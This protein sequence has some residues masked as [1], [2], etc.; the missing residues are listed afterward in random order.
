MFIYY[1]NRLRAVQATFLFPLL[2]DTADENDFVTTAVHVAGD[3]QI[4]KNGGAFANT[5][6][7]FTHIGNG[8]YSLVLT[9][10]EMNAVQI[11]VTV[12]DQTAVKVWRD[13]MLAIENYRDIASVLRQHVATAGGASTITLDAGASAVNDAYK[14]AQISIVSGT[15]TGQVRV[16]RSYVG[17][18]KVATVGRPWATNPDAT[19][20]YNIMGVGEVEIDPYGVD[21]IWDDLEGTEPATAI[22]SN[23]TMRRILQGLKRWAFNRGTATNSARTIYKDDSITALETQTFS[24]D[25]TTSDRGKSA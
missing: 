21:D 5:I 17:A 19:S 2:V 12:V 15:G 1:E 4:S 9:A 18:T 16:I 7:G 11:A 23:S 25:G 24:S 20:A 13:H 3:T 8:I 10:A 22:A 14:G 6:N